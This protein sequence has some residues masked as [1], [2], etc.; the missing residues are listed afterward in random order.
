MN[1]QVENAGEEMRE[2]EEAPPRGTLVM[3]ALRWL[4]IL[5]LGGAA[6]YTVGRVY[7][8]WG[9]VV[10]KK[11]LYRCPMHVAVVSDR[12]GAC[13]I[14]G[15]D[16]QPIEGAAQST[17]AFVCPWHPDY[18]G[19]AA[20]ECE[21]CGEALVRNPHRIPG[22]APVSIDSTRSQQIGV[23]TASVRRKRIGARVELAGVIALDERSLTR[24]QTR[25][26]GFLESVAVTETG[27]TVRKGQPLAS[28]FS[29]DIYLAQAELL[30][31]M[32]ALQSA[33]SN[34]MK[35]VHRS[36]VQAA[37]KRLSLLGVPEADIAALEKSRKAERL[38]VVRAPVS[39]TVL[40][41][42]AIA[43]GFVQPGTELFTLANFSRVW[44]IADVP[45]SEAPRVSRGRRAAIRFAAY[46]TRVFSAQVAFVLP[47]ADPAARTIKV[48]FELANPKGLL[49][50]G[51]FGRASFET[52]SPEVLVAPSEAIIDTGE[53]RYAFV[54]L[55]NG[56]FEPRRVVT[57]AADG[58]YVHV[59]SGLEEGDRV[60]TSA[61]FLI[62]SESRLRAAAAS[63]APARDG[64]R[65]DAPA[66]GAAHGGRP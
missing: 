53:L 25:F 26:A 30:H 8:L 15:M 41:R 36:I 60:V 14:C 62:D 3:A 47:I 45:E 48:R 64:G 4:I 1:P 55:P 24:V 18:G 13:N 2:G 10:A 61:A 6:T 28:L 56:R 58:V 11:A 17:K 20:G 54:A 42:G 5:A 34:E 32:S 43:G 19:D 59:R 37:R 22:L 39:G 9:S 46:P 57:G 66:R 27:A 44:F 63:M 33:S 50:P 21:V 31:A 49:R 65:A 29:N 16:L 51:M 40:Y 52:K 7:D 23:R 35:E 12:P 38:V